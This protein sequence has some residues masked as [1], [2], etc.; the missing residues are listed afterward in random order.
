MYSFN[1]DNN[2]AQQILTY[3]LL[4]GWNVFPFID[5]GTLNVTVTMEML[6]WQ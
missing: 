1:V 6:D 3:F 4:W 2:A 5:F